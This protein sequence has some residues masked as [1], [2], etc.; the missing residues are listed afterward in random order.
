[1]DSIFNLIQEEEP[2]QDLYHLVMQDRTTQIGL[3]F[4]L[5]RLLLESIPSDR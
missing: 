3:S 4:Y 1:M 2:K 5:Y